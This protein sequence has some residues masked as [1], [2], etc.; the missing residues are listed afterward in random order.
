MNFAAPA[1]LPLALLAAVPLLIHIFS[2]TRLH[3]HDFPSLRLLD[4]VRRERFSFVRLKE[5]LLLILRTLA[6]LA[7][8]LVPPRPALIARGAGLPPGDFVVVLDDSY[9]MGW[10]TRWDRARDAARRLLEGAGPGRRAGLLTASGS[11]LDTVLV[12][13]PATLIRQLDSLPIS[14]TAARLDSALALA[15]RAGGGKVT[16][17][18]VT[19]LQARA[20]P[21]GRADSIE[22]VRF[23]DVGADRAAN[24]AVI[25][26]GPENRLP[27]PKR[28][29]RV[30]AVFAN[31]SDRAITGFAVADV[32]GRVEETALELPPRSRTAHVFALALESPGAHPVRVE[33]RSDSLS[34]DDTR[35][36]V[37]TIPERLRLLAVETPAA[38]AALISAALGPDSASQFSLTVAPA[39]ALGRL[40]LRRFD[41]VLVTDAGALAPADLDRLELA[42][43][44]GTGLLLMLGPDTKPGFALAPWFAVTGLARGAGF[45][46]LAGLDTLAPAL[47]IFRPADFGSVRFFAHAVTRPAD[48]RPIATLSGGAPLMLEGALG[49]LIVWTFTAAPEN[50]DL[51]YRAAFV[52]LLHRC[53]SSVSGADLRR[54]RLVGDT[55][56]VFSDDPS[57]LAVQGPTRR[58]TARVLPG[59]G[60]ARLEYAD[61][62]EPGIY[63]LGGRALAVNLDPAE[64]DLE[65]VAPAEL[66]ARGYVVQTGVGRRAT[67][68]IPFLLYVAAAAFAAE[69]LLLAL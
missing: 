56:R 39:G 63:T 69:M 13:R 23:V 50:T 65:R 61:T 15:R 58:G 45:N 51:V 3:R 22:P 16:V 49:R 32:G 67:D 54:D 10:G 57:A 29:V 47:E 2:R 17:F 62:G 42:L 59:G 35:W 21:P 12:D 44:S 28:A 4:A 48:A 1:L 55:L 9:S 60:R 24:V 19:D 14:S 41:C 64:A 38:P 20:L 37:V 31:H 6:L 52:P 5:I 43:Q 34:S 18:A 25:D 8:L 26:V 53:L 27:V 30:R 7:L 33:F 11:L 36:A 46:T 40:D 68:L 66:A